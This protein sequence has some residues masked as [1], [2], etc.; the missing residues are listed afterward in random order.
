MPVG[1][2]IVIVIVIVVIAIGAALAGTLVLRELALRRQFGPEYSTLVR[3][4]GMRRAQ[5]EL[6][7]RRR[8]VAELGLRPVTAEQ[9]ARYNGEWTAAQ[10][11]FLDSPSQAAQ[12]AAA[13]VTTVAKDRGYRVDDPAQ[14]VKDLSVH[15]AHPLDGYRRA[16]KT[17]EQAATAPTEELRRAMLGYRAMFRDLLAETKADEVRPLAPAG[18]VAAGGTG[19]QP[20][21]SGAPV[22]RGTVLGRA[23]A[24]RSPASAPRRAPAARPASAA[25]PASAANPASMSNEE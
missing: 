2:I 11:R 13:L 4:V 12:A 18:A 17:T 5:A 21:P 23:K 24:G 20:V 1:A 7:E 10:E 3:E 14:L 8:R 9:R 6:A 25:S 22:V 15:H 16:T 19:R